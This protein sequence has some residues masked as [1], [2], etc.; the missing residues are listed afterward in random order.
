M[1][2]KNRT[3]TLKLAALAA[4]MLFSGISLADA[5]IPA[6]LARTLAGA[7]AG[8]ELSVIVTYSHSGAITGAELAALKSLG[9]DKGRTLRSL[10]IAGVL[11]TPSEIQALARQ[12]NVLSI[13][14]NKTLSYFN[15]ESRQISG[16]ARVVENQADFGKAIPYSGK[17]VAVVINDSGVDGTHADLQYGPHLVQNVLG[18]T[19]LAAW[20]SLLPITYTEGIAQTDLGSGHGTHCAGII[21]GTG[22]KSNGLYR[23]VAPGASLVGYGSGAVLLVLDS[24]GGLDYAI[25][26]QN[27]FDAPVRVISNSWGS[28]GSF[29]PTD[30]VNVAT[31]EAYKKG[32][33]SVFAAGNEGPGENTHNPYAQAPWVISVAAG[34]KNGRLAEFSSR[35]KR[36]ESGTFTTA[37]GKSWTYYNEPTIT[38]TGVDVISTRDLAGALPLLEAEGDASSIAPAYLPFYTHMSGTSMATPHVAGIVALMLEANPN[39]SPAQVKDILEK[40]ATNMTGREPW[41][42]GAGHVNAYG[43]VA[44]G[45]GIR[46]DFG[47]TVNS[48]RTFKANALLKDGGTRDFSVF[49]SPVGTNQEQSFTVGAGTAWITAR[50]TVDTNTVA[51]VLVSPTGQTYGSAI[52]LPELG[53]TIVASA[54]ATPGVWKIK[55]SGIGSV[56][57]NA[58][59][60]AGISNGYALPGTIEGTITFLDSA[61]Y[62]GLNDIANHPAKGAIQYAVAHRLVDGYSDSMF[63]PDQN[64]RR[65]ELA[66]YLVM[67]VSARQQLPLGKVPSFSDVPTTSAIYPFAESAVSAGAPLRDLSQKQAGLMGLVNGK[68]YPND[69]VSR[70]SLAYAFVQALGLQAEATGF[71]GTLSVSYN[72]QRIPVQDAGAI[73]A[74]LRG[75][76]QG[77]LDAGILNA[78][79]TLTQGPYDLVPTIHAYFDPQAWVTRAAYS[80]AAGRFAGVY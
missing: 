52:A 7:T 66:Q 55:A 80:V 41:E 32:I 3:T 8:Q 42:V 4:G 11:A 26:H 38:A 34:E 57:G 74:N 40:T 12:P 23:G 77:A 51:I 19:N 22:A 43:A 9:I 62:T 5:R 13:F 71:T 47:S 6:D 36:F 44:M 61:G 25:T 64:I 50:A 33:V 45:Q 1:D 68:F 17:G 59:D 76:A 60:P 35:G 73:P 10:P 54:P 63:R 78:R 70:L 16:A 30:P 58:L 48:L 72:G 69:N 67:G 31:Y 27:S 46:T 79:F 49:F 75:Y 2:R 37:D 20:D 18:T 15:L 14:P 65:S 24:V 21:G 53:S 56:S 39:L 29:D 28:S